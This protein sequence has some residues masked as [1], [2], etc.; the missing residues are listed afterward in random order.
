MIFSVFFTSVTTAL[1]VIVYPYV[2]GLLSGSEGEPQSGRTSDCEEGSL[3]ANA[4]EY[5]ACVGNAYLAAAKGIAQGAQLLAQKAVRAIDNYLSQ[6]G[7]SSFNITYYKYNSDGSLTEKVTDNYIHTAST[8]QTQKAINTIGYMV[9]STQ[10]ASIKG[11][12]Y[13][14]AD[15]NLY[16]TPFRKIAGK[17][18][19]TVVRGDSL[20]T[21]HQ[22]SLLDPSSV[23]N[24]TKARTTKTTYKYS[25]LYIEENIEVIDYENPISSYKQVNYSSSG[26][27]NPVEPDRI[28][29]QRDGAGGIYTTNTETRAL[30]LEYRQAVNLTGSTTNVQSRWLGQPGPQEK[31]VD[32]P[33]DFA[34]V[35]PRYD[36]NGLIEEFNPTRIISR[37]ESILEK[38]A[39]N[40]AKKIAADNSG[41]RITEVGTR[42]ELFGYYP[43]YPIA[44]NLSSL[45]KRY[46]L[47]AASSNWVFDKEN[48]LCSL[49]CF[50]TSEITS[51][52]DQDEISPYIY[53][54]VTKTENPVIVTAALINVPSTA[55]QIEVLSLPQ[56][57]TLTLSGTAV[58]IGDT[59]SVSDMN[60]GNLIFTPPTGVTT[61]VS[62]SFKALDTN[63]NEIGSGDNIYP[64]DQYEFLENISA[65]GGDF[66]ANT[67]NGGVDGDAGEF[68]L[69]T[70]PGGNYALDGGNF[71]TG[72]EVQTPE[73]LPFGIGNQQNGEA[74]VEDDY[75]ANVV[76]ED[77]N[78]IGT[79]QLPSPDGDNQIL[80]EI[81]ID[82]KFK[83]YNILD[84]TN[85]IILQ[86]G[87]NYGYITL[88]EGTP[89]DNGTITT[90]INYNLDFGTITSPIEP[91][92]SSSVS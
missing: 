29:I 32:L 13:K 76:D 15:G 79:D 61:Q 38:Y 81:E 26:S 36:S 33:I 5:Y 84:I 27:K 67:T 66:D 48:I 41:F 25:S 4:A 2:F 69:G 24:I 7:Y 58:V 17:D 55:T 64:A 92:L 83:T 3:N 34:P 39:K 72:E 45:G 89:I 40:E 46:G 78:T 1:A 75:G 47:R 54:A 82:L 10:T 44:L 37:Y 12:K 23:L 77:G 28:E 57:G 14:K 43:F 35:S 21:S 86:L 52:V 56:T 53:T 30:E 51:S 31:I 90:P 63:S 6:Q 70:R 20:R 62:F 8:N 11:L 42:A 74:N 19:S 68:D 59:I 71:D 65:D 9:Q 91:A 50:R 87:W 85:E 49:D 88:A 80:L 18:F 16:F 73:P 22:T 60:A